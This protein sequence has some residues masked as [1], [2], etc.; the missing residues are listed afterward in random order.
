MFFVSGIVYLILSSPYL[1]RNKLKL[2]L[3]YVSLMIYR[4]LLV[5]GIAIILIS[6]L[7]LFIDNDILCLTLFVTV[8]FIF[9]IY[10]IKTMIDYL[11]SIEI[12]DELM[13]ENKNL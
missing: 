1:L 8:I 4:N 6:I 5:T 7:R 11:K 9:V 12:M 13:K 2:N 10:T 3:N